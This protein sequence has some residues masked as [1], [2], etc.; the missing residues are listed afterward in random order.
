M[1]NFLRYNEFNE[2][3]EK[4]WNKSVSSSHLRS[5]EYDS[6][7]KV[8]EVEFW[9]DSKYQYFDVPK[10]IFREFADEPNLFNKVGSKIKALFKKGDNSSTYGT[11]FWAL[12]RRGSYTY[13]KL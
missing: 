9:N 7:T 11:R 13:E 12:I 5:I 10:E 3:F 6:D 1:S 8:L 4:T 2:L